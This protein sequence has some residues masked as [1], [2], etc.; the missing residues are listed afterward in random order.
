M[1]KCHQCKLCKPVPGSTHVQCGQV[2]KDAGIEI[3]MVVSL[4]PLGAEAEFKRTMGF[5]FDPHGVRSGWCAFPLNYDPVWL[6]GTCR[7]FEIQD[8]I[9]KTRAGEM[10]QEEAESKFVELRVGYDAKTN[11]LFPMR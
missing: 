2:I 11:T 10:T 6:T 5:G 7:I 1:V 8:V 4:N 9:E 3:S